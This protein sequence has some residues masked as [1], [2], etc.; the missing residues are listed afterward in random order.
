[1]NVH[2]DRERGPSPRCRF[3]RKESFVYFSES[4]RDSTIALRVEILIHMCNMTH[5][6]VGYDSFYL[7]DVNH[8]Y[9]VHGSFKCGQFL[10]HGYDSCDRFFDN[11]IH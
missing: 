3:P 5:S 2:P 1:M 9:V 8:S 7:Q 10:I 11:G 6:Y 4:H